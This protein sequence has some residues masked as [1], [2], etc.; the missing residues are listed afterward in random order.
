MRNSHSLE[1]NKETDITCYPGLDPGTYRGHQE[2][3]NK[4]PMK[5]E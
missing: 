1:E 3:Q 5:F 2:K 4:N